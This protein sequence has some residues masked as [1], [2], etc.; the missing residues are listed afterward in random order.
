MIYFTADLHFQHDNI[1]KYSDRPFKTIKQH[2]EM[3]MNNWNKTLNN[4]DIIYILGD[5][6]LGEEKYKEFYS[7]TLKKLK[8]EK[9]LII[10][11]HD[12]CS[13]YF[14]NKIGF[15]SVHFPYFELD[16]FIL[17]HD[18]ALSVIDRS[19]QFLCGHIHNL[20]TKQK[21]CVNVGVDVWNFKP[22]SIHTIRDF[23]RGKN[24][25]K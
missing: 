14:Y 18:P 20:F 13:P 19:K 17:V 2:D 21:N 22:V 24:D 3:L 7:R 5:F 6:C 10:G 15:Y 25:S 11:N 8:G 9:H 1:I 12:N 4:E 16:E 23:I